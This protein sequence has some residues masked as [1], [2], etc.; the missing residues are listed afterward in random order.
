MMSA[1]SLVLRVRLDQQAL[2]VLRVYR[3]L[4]VQQVLKEF[5]A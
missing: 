2:Q 5:R 1:L 3:V 4:Q